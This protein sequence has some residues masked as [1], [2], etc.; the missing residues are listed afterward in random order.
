MN[1]KAIAYYLSLFCFPIS[2]LSFI[3]ILYSLYFD[4]F[5]SIDLYFLT[6]I[7]SL[8]FNKILYFFGRKAEKK[9][10]F[11]DQI[12]LILLTYLIL[13]IFI[14]IPY[15]FSNYRLTIINSLFESFSGL[16]GTG[17][18]IFDNIKYLD[19]TLI[20]WRSSS[21]WLGGFYFLIFLLI[22]FSN[23]KFNYKLTYMVF[24][25]TDSNNENIIKSNIFKIFIIYSSLT[26]FI[27]LLLSFFDIRLFNALNLCMTLISTGGFL[28]TNSLD[29][30][31]INNK[32]EFA[33]ILS[34]LI[35]MFNFFL[36]FNI[37]SEKKFFETHQEDIFLFFIFLIFTLILLLVVK[38]IK[39]Q[40]AA[41][42]I[43]SSLGNSGL[44]LQKIPETLNLYFLF[45]AI[46]GGSIISNTS[47]I[48]FMRF[49]I[50]IKSSISEILK[51]V[52][53][54]N[55][56]NQNLLYSNKKVVNEDIR[57]AFLIFVM[58]FAS[59]FLLSGF[60]IL[61]TIDFK[62]SFTLSILTLTNTVNS[63]L[64]GN[65]EIDFSNL[66]TSS[67]IFLIIFMIVAKIELLSFFLIIKKL[68]FKN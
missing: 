60:L 29:Q 62:S 53:P 23:K 49:Y 22:I 13:S 24:N 31:I 2:F 12:T 17:F 57:I 50:L 52:R 6:L 37:F 28:P 46:I 61:D 8:I 27:F 7:S 56:I 65:A 47:G 26:F 39:F 36:I 3:N 18:T 15:Y 67:K 32:Q 54:N 43:L 21:Q 63:D 41:F 35:S 42:S 11:F 51:L 66:L 64:Y 19:P 5:L 59:L 1:F 55:V 20:L 4:Y 45:L 9:L 30:I 34:L 38:D 68:L 14:S 40:S 25:I 10:N 33:L 48:K 58:F 44:S 16:T